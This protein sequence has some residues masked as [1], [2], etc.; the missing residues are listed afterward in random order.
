MC[1]PAVPPASQSR[2]V[3]GLARV[4]MFYESYAQALRVLALTRAA[5]ATPAI[6]GAPPPRAA[7]GHQGR[8]G[9]AP[10]YPFNAPPLRPFPELQRGPC[11]RYGETRDVLR[12]RSLRLRVR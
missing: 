2:M 9:R 12:Q 11:R 5:C 3:A 8:L 10:V 4:S 6:P 1:T 7:Y